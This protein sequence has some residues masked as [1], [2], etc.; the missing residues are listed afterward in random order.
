[1]ERERERGIALI[2]VLSVLLL[3]SVVAISF[4]QT[5][6]T[7]VQLAGN[8]LGRARAEALAEAGVN[9]GILGLTDPDAEDQWIADG[10][11]YAFPY[12]DG[13]VLIRIHDEGGKIDLN[14]ASPELLQALFHSVGVTAT[15]AGR[16]ADVIGDWVDPDDLRRAS[17]AED[18]DYRAAGLPHGAKDA[19]F[20]SIEELQQVAGM[21][22]D[23]YEAVAPVL[24]IYSRQ[25]GIDLAT[26]S[27]QAL[28][29]LPGVSEDL[30]DS[31]LR[32]RDANPA[33]A[34]G[35]TVLPVEA[36]QH[37]TRSSRN[38]FTIHAQAR[39]VDGAVFVREAV[40]RLTGSPAHPVKIHAWKQGRLD[41]AMSAMMDRADQDAPRVR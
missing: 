31:F 37:V 17:G 38:V 4:L 41:A 32:E 27:R 9:R 21:S 24:T 19:P 35:S 5:T 2:A 25:Q 11:V 36:R 10:R 8:L 6:R 7:E 40:V 20:D 28:L 13:M 34:A 22:L 26:A 18:A 23:L 16:L 30:V 33:L 12:A 39:T 15:E 1:M 3:L 29:A 14:R